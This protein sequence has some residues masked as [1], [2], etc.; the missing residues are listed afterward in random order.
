[1]LKDV[2]KNEKCFISTEIKYVIT[3]ITKIDI[4]ES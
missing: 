3:K 1:M 4:N 2:N